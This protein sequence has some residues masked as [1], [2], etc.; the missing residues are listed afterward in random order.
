MRTDSQR[1]AGLTNLHNQ[2][3]G[4]P[5][6]ADV[7]TVQAIETYNV[8]FVGGCIVVTGVIN[9]VG[10]R[11]FSKD[12]GVRPFTTFQ[13]VVSSTAIQQVVPVTT[14]QVVVVGTAEQRICTVFAI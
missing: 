10:A 7:I 11:A 12:I 2:V 13:C 3:V 1:L 8:E 14:G 9:C 4:L 5:A 6:Q